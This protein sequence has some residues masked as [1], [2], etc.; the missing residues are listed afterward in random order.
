[1]TILGSRCKR[2]VK[3]IADI[4]TVAMDYSMKRG[5]KVNVGLDDSLT[6]LDM[7]A[8][9]YSMKRGLKDTLRI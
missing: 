7:V 3:D 8:M 6:A 5:L 4:R 9:D 2:W 1:M